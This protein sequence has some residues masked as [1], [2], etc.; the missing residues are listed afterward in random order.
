M[1]YWYKLITYLF[2]PFVPIYLFLRTLSKKEHPKRYKEKIS[3]IDISRD[4]GFLVW[5]HMAS[6][7]EA[8][9]VLSLIENFEKNEKIDKRNIKLVTRL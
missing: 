1:Q 2:Y 7:G 3:Q 9:S 6:V 5:L 4:K 8:M